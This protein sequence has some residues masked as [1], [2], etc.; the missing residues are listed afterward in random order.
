LIAAAFAVG[1]DGLALARS[2]DPDERVLL[3]AAIERA[4]ELVAARDEML[5]QRIIVNLGK[6]LK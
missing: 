3:R 1:A 4:G 2:I 5:A 6:A